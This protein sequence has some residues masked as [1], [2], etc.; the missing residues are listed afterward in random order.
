MEVDGEKV[1]IPCVSAI[2]ERLQNGTTEV[3]IQTRWKP[4][5]DPIYS[6]TIEIPAGLIGEYENVYETLKREVFEETGLTVIKIKPDIQTKK[7]SVAAKSD[8]AFSFLPF[9]VTQQ[10]KNGKPWLGMVFLCEV[11]SGKEPIAQKEEVRDVH[12]IA[13]EELQKIFKE[14]PEKIFT[15]QLPTLDYYFNYRAN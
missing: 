10:L 11:E 4:E 14:T 7:H 3:L 2:I 5:F 1:S 6:G 9:C 13:K 15:F 8:E 12:W